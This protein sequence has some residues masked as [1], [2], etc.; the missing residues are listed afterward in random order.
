MKQA[1]RF[2]I[3]DD[4]NYI[5]LSIR[6]LLEQYYTDVRAI[7]NPDQI[8]TALDENAYDV[9]ILDMNFS[10]G[11]TSGQD[12][13]HWFEEIK[14]RSPETMIIFITAYGG[15]E[16]AVEAVKR[17]AF[18]FITKPWENEKLLSTV[19]AAFKLS[20]AHKKVEKL[21]TEKQGLQSAF[22]IP[23]VDFIGQS[24]RMKVVFDTIV[25]VAPT[26]AN[27]L[28]LGEN[29]TGKELVARSLHLQSDRSDKPFISIDVGVVSENLFES[30]LYGHKKGAFTDAIEDRI[31][32]L[33]A[34]SGGTIFLDEIGNLSLPVQAKLL[35]VLQERVITRV[36]AND[37]IPVNVRIICATNMNLAEMVQK[38]TFRQ[39]LLYR[40]NTVTIELPPL[41]ER[42]T[43]LPALADYFL[44]LYKKKYQKGGLYVPEYVIK[45][46]TKHSWPGNVRELQHAI[47]RA[48]IMSDG[49]QLHVRDFSIS[50]EYQENSEGIADYNLDSLEKWAIQKAI[51]K[52]QGNISNAAKELGLSRG[53]LYRRMEKYEL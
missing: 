1:G 9:V 32:K 47:E 43:D 26:E 34:A 52:H 20:R 40:I 45:K 8:A 50:E 3:I 24:D 23:E 42:I 18:D 39:D 16:M 21:H 7:N 53:A 36:G 41:R 31:G 22:R 30:E 10:A 33:E 44:N 5:I 6:I 14:R 12:G 48:V 35:K 28:V 15:I 2:L 51:Q 4:D 37:I 17:G 27:V 13:L 38:G 11:D 19:S 25:K 46:L 29:G 49:K